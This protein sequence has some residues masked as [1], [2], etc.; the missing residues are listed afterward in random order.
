MFTEA[1]LTEDI[2][3]SLDQ[4]SSRTMSETMEAV[5]GLNEND[6]LNQHVLNEEKAEVIIAGT[7]G[8]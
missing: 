1:I 6:F 3:Q 2:F 8:K 4:V 7:V 5:K